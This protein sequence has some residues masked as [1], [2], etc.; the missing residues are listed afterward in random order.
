MTGIFCEFDA[1]PKRRWRIRVLPIRA[2]SMKPMPG[3]GTMKLIFAKSVL[4]LWCACRWSCAV[5]NDLELELSKWFSRIEMSADSNFVLRV[6]DWN[7]TFRIGKWHG[8]CMSEIFKVTPGNEFCLRG[9][10]RVSISRSSQGAGLYLEAR[11]GGLEGLQIPKAFRETSV[12]LEAGNGRTTWIIA[13]TLGQAYEVASSNVFEFTLPF[14][15]RWKEESDWWDYCEIEQ[16]E[17]KVERD[18][19][20]ARKLFEDVSRRLADMDLSSDDRASES[21]VRVV[22]DFK[23]PTEA[24]RNRAIERAT[25]LAPE[26]GWTAAQVSNLIERVRTVDARYRIAAEYVWQDGRPVVIGASKAVPQDRTVHAY[27]FARDGALTGC[28][29]RSFCGCPYDVIRIYDSAGDVSAAGY[30]VVGKPLL[31]R[32]GERLVAVR[33]ESARKAFVESEMRRFARL[34]S[35]GVL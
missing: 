3:K 8:E 32:E 21:I 34:L 26:K 19:L 24:E 27:T 18:R 25:A 15:G 35:V 4:A 22:K 9:G 13:P 33:D 5:A 16:Q 23:Q 20:A 31:R 2:D 14:V 30:D 10:E 7:R 11:E 1:C 28:F 6:V 17:R 12:A 29:R